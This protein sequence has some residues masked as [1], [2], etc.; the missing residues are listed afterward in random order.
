M[1]LMEAL[2]KISNVRG[3]PQPLVKGGKHTPA[4]LSR[5]DNFHPSPFVAY[6]SEP[7]AQRGESKGVE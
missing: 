2:A 7:T 6:G 1:V 3:P 4:P 5:G